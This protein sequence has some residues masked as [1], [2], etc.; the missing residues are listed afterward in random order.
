MENKCYSAIA[1]KFNLIDPI[2]KEVKEVDIR[3]LLTEK[4]YVL[5]VSPE[6][7]EME[8][9]YKPYDFV[10]KEFWEPKE[11]KEKFLERY[12]QLIGGENEY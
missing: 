10:I 6:P 2:P 12:Y 3:M 8:K 7:W 4:K 5:D 9:N 11:A 1:K